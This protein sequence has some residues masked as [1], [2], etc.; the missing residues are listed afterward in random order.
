[1]ANIKIPTPLRNLT[2]NL[3][4]VEIDGNKIFEIIDNLENKFPGVKSK[5]MMDGE[6]KHFVNIYIN[7]EDIRYLNSLSTDVNKTDEI[8]IVPAVAGG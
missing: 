5:I 6:L 1:M 8:S 4:S 2:D 7:G 3:T